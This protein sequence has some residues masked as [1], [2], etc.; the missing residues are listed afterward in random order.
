MALAISVITDAASTKQKHWTESGFYGL[1]LSILIDYL[2]L[3]IFILSWSINMI[4]LKRNLT[5]LFLNSQWL[6]VHICNYNTVG[7]FLVQCSKWLYMV[8]PIAITRWKPSTFMRI[9]ATKIRK[10]KLWHMSVLLC[11]LKVLPAY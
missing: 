7:F 2:F 8:H 10:Y 5:T 9:K 1:V 11:M 3:W 4:K 6:H